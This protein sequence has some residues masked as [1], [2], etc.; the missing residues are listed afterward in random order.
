VRATRYFGPQRSLAVVYVDR[1]ELVVGRSHTYP[2]V[3]MEVV[4]SL[5]LVETLEQVRNDPSIAGVVL[6]VESPGG[7][8]LAADAIWRAVELTNQVK[9]VVVSMGGMAA[10]GGYYVAMP[11]RRIFANQST[12]TGSIGVYYGK[13]DASELLKRIGVDIEVY[14]TAPHADADAFYRP[15]TAAEREL[16]RDKL[17]QFYQLFLERVANGRQLKVAE[18]GAV[19][20]GRV[21]TGAEAQARHLVDEVGGLRQAIEYARSLAGLPSYAPLVELPER[22]TSLVGRLLGIEGIREQQVAGLPFQLR[23]LARALAPFTIHSGSEPLMRLEL[24]PLGE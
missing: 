21:W 23:E 6:R 20:A 16:Y 8:S 10:S 18:V 15:F 2:F 12:I 24:I 17:Q 19:A 3:D 5:T 14:K 1:G 13:A 7:S 22:Q 4:G 11:S 9:P